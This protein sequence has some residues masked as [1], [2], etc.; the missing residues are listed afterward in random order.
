MNNFI[1]QYADS[2]I[3][4]PSGLTFTDL[5]N[6]KTKKI[7]IVNSKNERHSNIEKMIDDMF[8]IE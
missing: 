5:R 7:M 4:E 3:C 8:N 2:I 6:Q 1:K